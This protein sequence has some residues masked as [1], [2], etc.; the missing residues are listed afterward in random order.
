M[1]IW[2]G[3]TSPSTWK[4]ICCPQLRVCVHL[5]LVFQVSG[6][7]TNLSQVDIGSGATIAPWPSSPTRC[8]NCAALLCTL[9]L[10]SGF[11]LL[12]GRALWRLQ[13]QQRAMLQISLRTISYRCSTTIRRTTRSGV[14][15]LP[16]MARRWPF[17]RNPRRQRSTSWPA[18]MEW[19]GAKWNTQWTNLPM[20]PQALRRR[21]RSSMLLSSMTAELKL[22]V[23][24]RI[25]S[26]TPTGGQSRHFWLTALS[27]GSDFVKWRS[28]GF[29]SPT[30]SMDGCCCAVQTSLQSSGNWFWPNAVMTPRSSRWK[31]FFTSSLAKISRPRVG[32]SPNTPGTDTDPKEPMWPRSPTCLRMKTPLPMTTSLTPPSLLN[33]M[34]PCTMSTMMP[35]TWRT[36]MVGKR[37]SR[38]LTKPTR[39]RMTM[40]SRWKRPTAPTWM[41]ESV[42]L[43]SELHVAIG[44]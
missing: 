20:M 30:V 3:A 44:Q 39:K 38:P 22:H 40:T 15:A 42:L 32:A 7:A 19:H 27:T 12:P 14:L 41:P 43:R 37:L 5:Q 24:L 1:A 9:L 2:W 23:L 8:A 25:S 13:L 4:R 29:R 10:A 16:C 6:I 34:R 28:M 21:W 17:S 35:M 31:K 18:S 33:P 36:M 11:A 26:T